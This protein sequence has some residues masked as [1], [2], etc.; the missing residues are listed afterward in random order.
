MAA[1]LN[2]DTTTLSSNR[3]AWMEP[4]S[5]TTQLAKAVFLGL[6]VLVMVF[7]FVYVVAV[8][9]SSAKDVYAGGLILWPKNP[10]LEAYQAIMRGGIVVRSLG[11]SF[12]LAAVAGLL[13]IRVA[14][15]WRRRYVAASLVIIVGQFFVLQ[16]FT[17]LGHVTAWLIGLAVAVPVGRVT[18]T[19]REGGS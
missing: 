7:P 11:V 19:Q 14:D 5:P 6:V 17:A 15:R 2:V 8:S 9:F 13:V 3:P 1:E 4:P 10:S 12:G 16:D 18:R